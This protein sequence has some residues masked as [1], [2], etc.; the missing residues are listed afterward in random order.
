MPT[1]TT[2]AVSPG[3]IYTVTASS[4]A[5]VRDVETDK[6]LCKANNGSQGMFVAIGGTVSMTTDDPT[7]TITQASTNSGGARFEVHQT[8]PDTGEEGVIY[9]IPI[10]TST[11][12]ENE[13]EEWIWV[14]GEWERLGTTGVN[15]SNYATLTDANTYS[16][17]NTFN[18]LLLKNNSSSLG[19]T[20]VLNR[21]E[22]D[23]RYGQLTE[24]NTWSGEQYI[25]ADGTLTLHPDA[26]INAYNAHVDTLHVVDIAANE[27]N[28]IHMW[29]TVNVEASMYIHNTLFVD[30]IY[31][32]TYD[33]ISIASKASVVGDLYVDKDIQV[34]G[35]VSVHV[36]SGLFVDTITTVSGQPL[37]I[38]SDLNLFGHN[39]SSVST[40]FADILRPSMI[41]LPNSSSNKIDVS[42]VRELQFINSNGNTTTLSGVS[43][44]KNDSVTVAYNNPNVAH[45]N[46]AMLVA[47]PEG[48]KVASPLSSTPEVTIAPSKIEA[49]QLDPASF[50]ENKYGL[51][52]T[53]ESCQIFGIDFAYGDVW[54]AYPLYGDARPAFS[55]L[56]TVKIMKPALS[57]ASTDTAAL[58]FDY[59]N[60]VLFRT[61]PNDGGTAIFEFQSG[62]WDDDSHSVIA[63]GMVDLRK[64]SLSTAE[65]HKYSLINKSELESLILVK[66][67]SSDGRIA[68]GPAEV[69]KD[70]GIAIGSSAGVDGEESISI[71]YGAITSGNKAIAIG[72]SADG[73]AA[74]QSISIGY[75][76]KGYGDSAIAI[77]C[78]AE[79][80]DA[81]AIAIGYGAESSNGGSVAIGAGAQS[82]AYGSVAIGPGTQATIKEYA[83]AIGSNSYSENIVIGHDTNAYVAGIAIG[84]NTEA[85][86]GELN[87]TVGGHHL[88]NEG[89][90][91][92]MLLYGGTSYADRDTTG[93]LTFEIGDTLYNEKETDPDTHID[94]ITISKPNLW[95][96]LDRAKYRGAQPYASY[97]T[98]A[99]SDIPAL[100]PNSITHIYTATDAAI[101]LSGITL[102]QHDTA[103]TTAELWVEVTSAGATITWPDD[104]L[105]PDEA[106]P[107]T[108]PSFSG[109]EEST[110]VGYTAQRLYCVTLRTQPTINIA[111]GNADIPLLLATIAY[112][113]DHKVASASS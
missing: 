105:W 27:G 60:K 32:N 41:A 30:R 92:T 89:A 77:G 108:A 45:G 24:N 98:S 73:N 22:A 35:D 52:I 21:Y 70:Y 40:L 83:I 19:D 23:A 11:D 2:Q 99:V 17:N 82:D 12:E 67:T 16:G 8:R 34:Q 46:N 61:F 65:L 79:S 28:T 95:S 93:Y 33:T 75:N 57:V 10:T 31:A 47:A 26:T 7:A 37:N 48:I 20:S 53:P 1:T 51:R 97:V 25:S 78:M 88:D 49:F 62:H 6:L 94:S 103:V 100:E 39:I 87:I 69:F 36:N 58:D 102:A 81:V 56:D 64:P 101:D 59:A 96:A 111:T 18:G 29:S 106:D 113:L 85:K 72:S 91:C 63:T 80:S 107:T 43:S 86:V 66:T 68:I 54:S 15:L 42:E 71:G 3:Y 5:I 9:L 90:R 110:E 104:M 109:P 14:K 4:E 38:K 55:P 76:A 74:A 112:T 50:G 44:L 13:Y 84:S